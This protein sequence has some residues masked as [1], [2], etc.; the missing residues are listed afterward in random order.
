MEEREGGRERVHTERGRGERKGGGERE[1]EKERDRQTVTD[2]DRETEGEKDKVMKRERE[3]KKVRQRQRDSVLQQ[4]PLP[5]VHSSQLASK[6]VWSRHSYEFLASR[7]E[8][9][10]QTPPKTPWKETSPWPKAE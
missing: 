4:M 8:G 7:P 1:R 9:R 3:M 5:S 6:Y 2:T 10:K